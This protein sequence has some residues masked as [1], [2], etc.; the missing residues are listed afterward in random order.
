MT[1][2]HLAQ[3]QTECIQELLKENEALKSENTELHVLLN[4][5]EYQFAKFTDEVFKLK[6]KNPP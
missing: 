2:S 3:A 6:R 5:W 1:S 4:S